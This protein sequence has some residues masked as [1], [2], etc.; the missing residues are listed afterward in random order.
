METSVEV[1]LQSDQAEVAKDKK[2]P[3]TV[4]TKFADVQVFGTRFDVCA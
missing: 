3:F 1:N 4:Q 2:H